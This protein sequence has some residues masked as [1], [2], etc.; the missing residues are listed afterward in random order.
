MKKKEKD[1]KF[2]ILVSLAIILPVLISV[3]YIILLSK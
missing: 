2:Y 1:I 3:L